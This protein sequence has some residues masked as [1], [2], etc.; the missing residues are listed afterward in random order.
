MPESDAEQ[1][2]QV[3]IAPEAPGE[4]LVA[5][6]SVAAGAGS[7]TG[8]KLS[9]GTDGEIRLTYA[10]LSELIDEAVRQLARAER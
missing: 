7:S 5:D 1:A 2:C 6:T 10:Q 3:V 9:V 8:D 4:R